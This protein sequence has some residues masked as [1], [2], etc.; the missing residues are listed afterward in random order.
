MVQDLSC[1]ILL[2]HLKMKLLYI[3]KHQVKPG[4]TG[5]AQVNGYRGDTSIK[6]RIEYDIYYIENWSIFMEINILFKTVF[7][8]IKNNE[9]L[10]LKHKEIDNTSHNQMK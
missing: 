2:I 4:I 3:V 9:K 10:E 6:K 1:H 7:K 5:L 8:G